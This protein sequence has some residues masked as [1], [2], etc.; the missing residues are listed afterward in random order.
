MK[1]KIDQFPTDDYTLNIIK[2]IYGRNLKLTPIKS[3]KTFLGHPRG[4]ATLFF[5]E[6]WERFSYYGMRAI[7]LFYMFYSVTEGGLGFSKATA[8]SIMSIYGALVY[9][10]SVLGGFMSDRLWGSRKTVLIGGILIMLGH[11]VLATP[12]GKAALFISI[13]LITFGTGMLKPNVSEMVGSLY[14]KDDYR[15]EAGFNIFVFGINVGAFIAPI[16]VGYIGQTYNFH[17]GFSLAAIGMFFGLVQYSI[18]GKLYLSPDSMFPND[19]LEPEEVR[20]LIKKGIAWVIGIVLTCV[21]MIEF[22]LF[23]IGNVILVLSVLS[24]GIPIYY[25]VVMLTSQKVTVSER[26]RVVAYL[27]LFLAAIV[28]WIIEEQGSVILAIFAEEQTKLTVFGHSFPASWFQSMNPLFIM[29]YVPCFAW[30]WSKLK[31]HQPSSATKFSLGLFFAGISFLW[32]ML[33]GMLYGTHTK[34]SPLWL[35][36]SWALVII[37]EMLISPIG[38]S[39]TTKLA[40]QAFR[41]QM[42][43]MWF[44]T[45][46]VAQAI[47]SQI[48]KFYNQTTEIHYFGIIGGVT[49]ILGLI[50]LMIAPKIKRLATS[51]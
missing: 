44:L 3:Q 33:P 36:M 31:N 29:L 10:T 14:D 34:V 12:Y 11:I 32:M 7:L 25:F 16:I 27:P 19:P 37:G 8:A 39:T 21:I 22:N 15:R 49:I 41:S 50:L 5:T 51:D 1:P 35:V 20:G 2:F 13:I 9:L 6:M 46:A 42:M 18:D 47:N 45:D 48:V 30:L 40:P 17:I 43:S 24:I 4:L 38:L 26:K 28:F 23:N